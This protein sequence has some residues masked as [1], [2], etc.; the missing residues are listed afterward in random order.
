MTAE[1]KHHPSGP[2]TLAMVLAASAG[3]IDAFIDIRV[4][5]VFVANMSGNLVRLGIASGRHDTRAG[6]AS[7]VA[8]GGFIGGAML[9]T[10]RIEARVRRGQPPTPVPLLG[11]ESVLLAVLAVIVVVCRIDYSP[12][13]TLIDVAVIVVGAVAMGIQAVALRRVGQIAVS[14]TYGTG[15]VV[16]LAEKLALGFRRADRPGDIRRRR[17]ILVLGGV[18]VSY[19]VGAYAGTALGT[20]RALLVIPAIIPAIAAVLFGRRP[21]RRPVA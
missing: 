9:A 5:P 3:F 19:V 14:T 6:I 2:L 16:R 1:S 12:T 10:A 4:T 8:L 17:S 15:A 11:V 21:D 18:L 7:L 20:A 13:M